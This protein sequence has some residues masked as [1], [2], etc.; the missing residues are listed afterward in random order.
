[1]IIIFLIGRLILGFYYLYSAF[2][3]FKN[4]QSMT[5]F[6]SSKDVPAPTLAVIGSGFL[7]L[8]AGLSFLLG[9]LPYIGVIA[10]V[11]F[12]LPVTFWMH[13]FWTISDPAEKRNQRIHFMKNMALMG[14][15]LLFL[16]I[17]TPW[18]FSLG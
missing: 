5:G 12:F 10:L 13:N 18:P 3:H 9:F 16:F 11:L 2:N 15:A 7:L 6:V 4:Y 17:P 1:M 8:I 14:S